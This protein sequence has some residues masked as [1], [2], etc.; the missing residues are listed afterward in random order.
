MSIIIVI[1]LAGRPTLPRLPPVTV[2]AR[3]PF[4]WLLPHIQLSSLSPGQWWWSTCTRRGRLTCGAEAPFYNRQL[5]Y[6]AANSLQR[7]LMY[8]IPKNLNFFWVRLTCCKSQFSCS[9]LYS[10]D[11]ALSPW[12]GQRFIQKSCSNTLSTIFAPSSYRTTHHRVSWPLFPRPPS[13]QP[14]P[15]HLDWQFLQAA[16]SQLSCSNLH[17]SLKHS[18]VQNVVLCE[19]NKAQLWFDKTRRLLWKTL[20]VRMHKEGGKRERV[21][22]SEEG[23]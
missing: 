6:L 9:C 19:G 17:T 14:Q 8:W 21:S 2:L 7:L 4:T 15:F 12:P 18:P 13:P 5:I 1:I 11:S 16:F 20:C 23:E 22:E 10:S 3:S